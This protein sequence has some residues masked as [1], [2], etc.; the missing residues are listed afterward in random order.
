M[1]GAQRAQA[2]DL[3]GDG[4]LDIVVA[5]MIAGGELNPRLASLAW[6][7]QVQP[8]VFERHTLELGNSYH[9]TLDIADYNGDGRPDILV[10]WF[11]FTRPLPSLLDIWEGKGR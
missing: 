2:V 4:D 9:A 3:D 10:G 11:A 1:P 7:E 6:L 8:G 5:A